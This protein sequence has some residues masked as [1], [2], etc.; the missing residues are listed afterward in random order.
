M[1]MM[2]MMTMHAGESVCSTVTSCNSILRFSSQ[3]S[4]GTLVRFN[5]MSP[6]TLPLYFWPCCNISSYF[7][8]AE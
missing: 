1:M 8:G 5:K 2:M 7:F 3:D 6:A 4:K